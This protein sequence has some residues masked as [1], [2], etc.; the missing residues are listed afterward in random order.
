MKDT[1]NAVSLDY[2]SGILVARPVA[3]NDARANSHTI[4]NKI[5]E[6]ENSNQNIQFRGYPGE[7]KS[8]NHAF[9]CN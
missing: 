3:S 9:Y 6:R 2:N 5:P 4:K 7:L 1:E 8:M